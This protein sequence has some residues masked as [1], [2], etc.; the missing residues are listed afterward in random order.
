MSRSVWSPAPLAGPRSADTHVEAE[1]EAIVRALKEHG[2]LGVREL[3]RIVQ[4]RFWGPGRFGP[5]LARAR[6]DGRIRREGR[7]R[8]AAV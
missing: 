1:V 8:Y 6:R 2:P 4:S 7:R 5:A 3:R